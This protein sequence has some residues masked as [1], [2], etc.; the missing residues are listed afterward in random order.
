MHSP[1]RDTDLC[2]LVAETPFI[3][4]YDVVERESQRILASYTELGT[5]ERAIDALCD[6]K[7][8]PED[9]LFVYPKE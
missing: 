4:I 8:L 2:I 6:D 7:P 3:Y 5:A 9:H 1:Y